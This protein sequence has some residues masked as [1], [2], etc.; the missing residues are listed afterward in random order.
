M[1][2]YSQKTDSLNIYWVALKMHVTYFETL[3]KQDSNMVIY[4]ER[5]NNLF[6]KFPMS[7]GGHNIRLLGRDEIKQL[8]KKKSLELISIRPIQLIDSSLDLNIINYNVTYKK[9]SFNYANEGGS[10]VTFIFDCTKQ[11]FV[12]KNIKQVGN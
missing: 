3:Q 2:A 9:R 6:Y 1:K 11:C 10:I 7:I 4:I 5:D 8:A 12:I